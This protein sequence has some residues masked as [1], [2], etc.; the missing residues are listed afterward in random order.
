MLFAVP[1]HMACLLLISTLGMAGC[2]N[3]VGLVSGTVTFNGK[4]LSSGTVLFHGADGN[5]GHAIIAEDGG[6]EMS[7]APVGAARITVV[8]HARAPLGLPSASKPHPDAIAGLPKV[9]EPPR[10]GKFTAIP[11]RYQDVVSSPL[12]YT[13]QTGKQSH[14]IELVP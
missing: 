8:S 12:T 5:V 3:P 6:Y 1:R 10:D 14:D 9:D 13:V 2:G 11:P 4:V 7:D